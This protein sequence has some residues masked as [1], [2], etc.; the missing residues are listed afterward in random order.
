MAARDAQISQLKSQIASTKDR[1]TQL[2]AQNLFS[3]KRSAGVSQELL[4]KDAAESGKLWHQ[5]D[6]LQQQNLEL[7]AQY[8]EQSDEMA[9]VVEA[10]EATASH[11]TKKSNAASILSKTV[12]AN[13]T[14]LRKELHRLLDERETVQAK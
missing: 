2:R 9:P 8:E 1:I 6:M 14:S 12:Q 4:M 11:Q 7:R 10:L 5:H 13:V 3:K